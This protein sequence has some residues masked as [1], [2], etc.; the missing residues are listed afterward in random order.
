LAQCL[1]CHKVNGG[2]GDA[3]PDLSKV[4][5]RSKGD[6]RF[7]LESL[8]NTHAKLAKGFGTVTVVSLKTEKWLTEP[9][10]RNR[11]QSWF[12]ALPT[13]ICERFRFPQSS[14]ESNRNPPCHQSAKS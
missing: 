12:S 13:E 3:G 14:S 2:G 4:T 6:H 8:I 10:P 1:R 9:S 7:L 5:E 11:R